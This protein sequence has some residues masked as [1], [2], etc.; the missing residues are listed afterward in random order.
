MLRLLAFLVLHLL[1]LMASGATVTPLTASDVR[2]ELAAG[3]FSYLR[4]PLG[5][6]RIEDVAGPLLAA[7]FQR[8]AASPSFG[9]AKD[10]IIAVSAR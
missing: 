9:Y 3:D 4:D 2:H 6:W 8:A 5:Q 7:Q 10:V 1:S